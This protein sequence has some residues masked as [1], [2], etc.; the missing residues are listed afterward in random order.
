ML[1]PKLFF[2]R[3]EG[4]S[5]Y[6]WGL[7]VETCSLDAAF[8]SATVRNRLQ[9]LA[10]AG[11]RLRA[12]IVGAKWP[13]LWRVLQQWSGFKCRIA[14]FRVAGV[15]RCDIRTC[16]ITRRKSFFMACGRRN[17]FAS[18]SEDDLHFAWQAYRFGDLRRHFTLQAQHFR[19]VAL[20]VF[21]ESQCQVSIK[22]RL[23]ANSVAGLGHP[24]SFLLHASAAFGENLSCVEC[25]F[26]WQ[27]QCLARSTLHT[28]PLHFTLDTP[29]STLGST[30]YTPHFILHTPHLTL[31]TLH[32][33]LHTVQF[34]LRT[35]H[36][37]LLSPHS[38]LYTPQSAL[39]TPNSTLYTPHCTLYPPHFT[40]YTPLSI[41]YTL[42]SSSLHT[43]RSKLYTLNSTLHTFHSTIC[44]FHSTLH[45]LHSTLYTFHST[46][47]TPHCTVYTPH[48]TLFTP[49]ST[50]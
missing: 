35:L 26:A 38:I 42:H 19:R 37:T 10:T 33:T 27:P 40:L 18:F 23:R 6:F 25:S 12:T 49:L 13:C 34:T 30:L 20:R 2:P 4:F 48:L 41:L 36:S 22:W 43:S 8:V 14:S 3:S 9:P 31:Y 7:G 29:H 11:N 46:L 47:C 15:A 45:T 44:T 17:T 39:R 21:G 16:F 32:C 5:F 1:N 50:L 28:F 24:E